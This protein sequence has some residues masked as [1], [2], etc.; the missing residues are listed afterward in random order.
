MCTHFMLLND[1][2]ACT[3]IMFSLYL[4]CIIILGLK[5]SYKIMYYLTMFWS[6][7][8]FIPRYVRINRIKT[9]LEDVIQ[10]FKQSGYQLVESQNIA[11]FVTEVN[12]WLD[13]IMSI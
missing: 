8:G 4:T 3:L 5:F 9:S 2:L 11:S 12:I 10:D 6:V 13:M 7:L 1:I